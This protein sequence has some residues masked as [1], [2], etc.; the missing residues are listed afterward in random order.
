MEFLFESESVGKGTG[1]RICLIR[2]PEGAG[3]RDIGL[4][5]KAAVG[6]SLRL[7]F[8]NDGVDIQHGDAGEGP[9]AELNG[10]I[11]LAEASL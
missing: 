1:V 5:N 3:K 4:P 8:V 6:H 11:Q 7:G 9:L 10:S 2:E